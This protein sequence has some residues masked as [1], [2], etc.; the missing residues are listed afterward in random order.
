MPKNSSKFKVPS[1]ARIQNLNNHL[2]EVGG[3]EYEFFDGQFFKKIS[4]LKN[5]SSFGEIALQ[6]KC[7]RTAAIKAEVDCDFAILTKDGYDDSI[8][9]IT[10]TMEQNRVTFLL[11]MHIFK[12]FSRSTVL[13]FYRNFKIVKFMRGQSVFSEGDPVEAVYIIF[14]GDFEMH[15]KLPKEDKR[16]QAYL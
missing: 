5:G 15:K 3:V 9:Q 13:S 7:L 11:N 8:A 6:R 10:E 2:F 16:K 14:K 4:T 12:G 1:F